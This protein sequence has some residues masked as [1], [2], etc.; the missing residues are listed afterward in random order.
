MGW[1]VRPIF[2]RFLILY[3]T[4]FQSV[5]ILQKLQGLVSRLGFFMF[6]S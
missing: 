3:L 4:P 1:E 5:S 2:L 6:L